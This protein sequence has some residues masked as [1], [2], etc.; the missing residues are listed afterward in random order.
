M[1]ARIM[2][3][4]IQ[5]GKRNYDIKGVPYFIIQ[6]H[7]SSERDQLPYGLS[8]AQESYTFLKIFKELME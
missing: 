6:N 4:E 1:R 7:L 5:N 3:S 8:G 2:Q